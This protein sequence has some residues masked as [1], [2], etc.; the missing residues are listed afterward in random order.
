MIIR[1]SRTV[2][3]PE[4]LLQKVIA[5]L[6]KVHGP[7]DFRHQS[8][9]LMF[10]VDDFKWHDFFETC[11]QY[12]QQQAIEEV[13]YLVVLTELRNAS[14]W[15][16]WFSDR[17]ERTIFIHA[18]DWE[19][20]I[21]SEP[22]FPLAYEVVSN[23]LQSLSYENLKEDLWQYIHNKA[24]GCMNDMCEWKPDITLK[25]RTGDICP[26]CMSMMMKAKIPADIVQ[27]GINVFDL[28]RRRML[29]SRDWQHSMSFDEKLPFTVAITKR[30]LGTTQ[31]PLRKLLMLIDH[32]DALVR[33][34]VLMMIC[35]TKTHDQQKSFLAEEN[36]NETPS[37]GNW[38]NALAHLCGTPGQM[39]ADLQLP[40]NFADRL[41][42]V[43][44]IANEEKI[45]KIRNEQ[46]AHGYIACHDKEYSTRFMY[47]IPALENI[48]QLLSPLFFR[49]KYYYVIKSMRIQNKQFIITVNDLS[50]SNP[51]FVE[52]EEKT[53]FIN[54]EDIPVNG[55]V[56][57]VTHDLTKWLDASP[58]MEY[59]ECAQCHQ[60]RVLIFDGRY[61]LDPYIGH[62][63]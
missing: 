34:A 17:G 55:K 39:L 27:Q 58:Y 59:K 37:L 30:K 57:L 21:Y 43:I 38:V 52:K 1:I 25:L 61:L 26:D 48:E 23:V 28:L 7:L 41:S 51:A 12:R 3:L 14:N 62:R 56:H 47:C 49:F 31:D 45:V 24:I 42:K 20:Y 8:P 63:F 9:P 2:R 19:S 54:I 11:T 4:T 33:T 53:E 32:F 18:S 60:S 40:D 46:R 36:L 44:K 10:Q 15:F 50:G 29:F 5:E 13:D 6:Q 22:E 16:S 35:L